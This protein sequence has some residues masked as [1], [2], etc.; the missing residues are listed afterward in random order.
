MP[1][2]AVQLQNIPLVE[3]DCFHQDLQGVSLAVHIVHC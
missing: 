3:Q 1:G 2:K